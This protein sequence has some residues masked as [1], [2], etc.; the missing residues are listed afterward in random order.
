MAAQPAEIDRQIRANYRCWPSNYIARDLLEGNDAM[1]AHYTD[2]KR[3]EFIAA[4][5][6]RI[7]DAW[8]TFADWA[9]SSSE[10]PDP[11]S[12]LAEATVPLSHIADQEQAAWETL[13]KTFS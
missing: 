5:F 4:E 11:A 1:R 12:C 2:D 6:K 3:D 10:V 7:G 13:Y 8:E 9:K